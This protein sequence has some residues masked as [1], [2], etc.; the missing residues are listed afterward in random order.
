[1]FWNHCFNGFFF[2]KLPVIRKLGWREEVSV[3]ATWG[4]CSFENNGNLAKI[5]AADMQAPMLFP[6]G[7]ST[8]GKL[9]YVE[10]GAGISNILKF[11][12]VDCYWRATYRDER[13]VVVDDPTQPH[14]G[15]DRLKTPNFAV[16]IGAEFKF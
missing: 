8:L 10:F 14:N 9:P 6:N 7:T 3:R 15:L 11:I 1:M 16:K 4:S 13:Y 2:G 12:R 5:S